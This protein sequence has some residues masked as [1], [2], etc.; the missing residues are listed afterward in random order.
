MDD[1]IRTEPDSSLFAMGVLLA[2][3]ALGLAT[4]VAGKTFVVLDPLVAAYAFFA[5]A[6]AAGAVYHARREQHVATAAHGVAVVGWV[7]G[8]VGQT[9]AGPAFVAFSLGTLG[10]SGVA[11]FFAGLQSLGLVGDVGSF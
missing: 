2:M 4:N 5:V 8:I 3:G 9:V 7:T 10:A 6:F 1:V 11:L